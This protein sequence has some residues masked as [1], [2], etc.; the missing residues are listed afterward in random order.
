MGGVA[1]GRAV[2]TVQH[3]RRLC[4]AL[5]T[6]LLCLL[7]ASPA[8][9]LAD[10][11]I[12]GYSVLL[13]VTDDASLYVTEEIVYDPGIVYL[14]H[15]LV[16]ELPLRAPWTFW[17]Q[18]VISVDDVR[19]TMD[20]EAVPLELRVRNGVLIMRLGDPRKSLSGPVRYQLT[21]RVRGAFARAGSLQE[22]PQGVVP[23]DVVLDWDAVGTE[24]DSLVEDAVVRLQAPSAPN[25]FRCYVGV[26]GSRESCQASDE[27]DVSTGGADLLGPGQGI[28]VLA[29]FAPSNFAAV[30]EPQLGYGANLWLAV[31]FSL[32]FLLLGVAARTRRRMGQRALPTPPVFEVPRSLSPAEIAVAYYGRLD[33][34]ALAGELLELAAAGRVRAALDDTGTFGFVTTGV[35][36][37]AVSA[38]TDEVQEIL[39]P[40]GKLLSPQHLEQRVERLEGL[41]SRLLASAISARLRPLD[42]ERYKRGWKALALVASFALFASLFVPLEQLGGNAMR[43]VYAATALACLL[44]ALVARK[45]VPLAY[46]AEHMEFR[47]EVEGFRKLMTTDA[48]V[49]RTGYALALGLPEHAVYATLLPYAVALDCDTQWKE[50]FPDLS[51]EQLDDLGLR[52]LPAALHALAGTPLRNAA[53]ARRVAA[54]SA[55][56]SAPSSGSSGGGLGGG[57]GHSW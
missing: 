21:Y 37:R 18:R 24:W 30:P 33:D 56:R 7:G 39:M 16:R 26:I 10:E 1:A 41:Q 29:A 28:T 27:E 25:L 20:G 12:R 22:T 46:Q 8:S 35:S 52:G 51:I 17:K 19:A 6:A 44:G 40:H 34:S 42:P 15:G 23:S 9:G 49:A 50:A 53:E 57:G 14:H 38:V 43:L 45:I 3:M 4:L 36:H 32:P 48:A 11:R 47:A 5:L 2:G 54:R 31:P 55:H 13:R